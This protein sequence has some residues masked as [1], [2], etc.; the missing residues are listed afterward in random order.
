MKVKVSRIRHPLACF[1]GEITVDGQRTAHAEEIKL[2]FDYFPVIDDQ[3]TNPARKS[4]N[5]NISNGM[6]DLTNGTNGKLK[7]SFS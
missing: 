6:K 1:Q 3:N 7:R 4:G 5:T 2:A